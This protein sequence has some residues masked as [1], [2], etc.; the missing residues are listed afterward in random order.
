MIW[1][2]LRKPDPN[3]AQALSDRFEEAK[4]GWKD[5]FAMVVSAYL[6]LLVPC[7]LLLTGLSLL[8]LWIFGVL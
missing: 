3:D 2:R 6:V 7:L 4:V 8:M 1:K 5:R